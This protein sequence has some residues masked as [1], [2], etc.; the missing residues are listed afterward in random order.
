MEDKNYTDLS[1]LVGK[2]VVR[3]DTVVFENDEE[4]SEVG[5]IVHACNDGGVIDC[6]VAFFGQEWP[7]DNKKPEQIPY[8][9][10]YFLSSLEEA[11]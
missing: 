6:Y 5:V 10:R 2:R 1:E 9:L 3:K 11:K 7:S 4:S 8:I